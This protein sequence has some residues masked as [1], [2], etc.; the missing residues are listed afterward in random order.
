MTRRVLVIDDETDACNLVAA[1]LEPLGYGILVAE[2]GEAGLALAATESPDMIILDLMMPDMDGYEVCRALRR[3]P[4]TRQIPV[5]MITA[6]PDP[7]LNREAYAAGA[8]ACVPKPFR[9]EALVVAVE[10]VMAG[11]PRQNS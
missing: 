5:I 3:R 11:I 2:S 10:A 9:R 1:F 8:Q 4:E 6:S 7:A